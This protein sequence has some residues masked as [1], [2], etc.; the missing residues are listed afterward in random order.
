MGYMLF[1]VEPLGQREERG[2]EA[3][4]QVFQQMLD[5]AGEMRAA[6]VLKAVESLATRGT[7]VQVRGGE[8]RVVDGPFAEARELVGGFFQLAEGVSREQAFEWAARCPAAQWATVEVR[9]LAPC[10]V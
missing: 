6:G 10:Y 7:R 9:E 5:F 1:I 2:L 8:K 4:K 3:G